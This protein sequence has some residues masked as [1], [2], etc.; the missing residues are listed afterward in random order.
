MLLELALDCVCS[1]VVEATEFV[2]KCILLASAKEQNS[3]DVVQNSPKAIFV[4][5]AVLDLYSPDCRVA[6]KKKWAR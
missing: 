3:I 1:F 6:L 2:W 4:Y 5:M